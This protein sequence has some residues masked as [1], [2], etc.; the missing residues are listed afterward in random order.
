M[1]YGYFPILCAVTTVSNIPYKETNLLL[2][3]TLI[4][5]HKHLGKTEMW[6]DIQKSCF[7]HFLSLG[8]R[9][10][11]LRYSSFL[12]KST[13]VYNNDCKALKD[14]EVTSESSKEKQEGWLVKD[15]EGHQI[16]A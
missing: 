13:I 10:E 2:I 1:F 8:I 5:P 14:T 12:K 6:I 4:I 7:I 3:S 9:T 16:P 15:Y 11:S